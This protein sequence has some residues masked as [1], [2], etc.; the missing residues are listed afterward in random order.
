MFIGVMQFIFIHFKVVN[1]LR[2]LKKKLQETRFN[3]YRRKP[4]VMFSYLV[5][6]FFSF[7]K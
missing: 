4:L 2:V 7:R 3:E 5:L 6:L 1:L